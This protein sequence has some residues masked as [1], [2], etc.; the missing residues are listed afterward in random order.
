MIRSGAADMIQV[1]R[2]RVGQFRY[3]AVREGYLLRKA[4]WFPEQGVNQGRRLTA[5]GTEHNERR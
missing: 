5:I 2:R 3:C 4:G 1:N